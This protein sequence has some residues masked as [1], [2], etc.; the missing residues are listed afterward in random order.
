MI[1]LSGIPS[2][3]PLRLVT[4]QLKE[5]G[6]KFVF[7]NQREFDSCAISLEVEDGVVGGELKL[8]KR[9]YS[10]TDFKGTYSRI[11][12][13]RML[14]EL[15]QESADSDRR[16]HCRNFHDTLTQWME[17]APGCVINRAGPMASN[18]S[19]PYQTQLIRECGFAV[20]E[21]L[22]TNDPEIVREFRSRLGRVVYKSISAVRSIVQELND[23]DDRRLEL[24]RD[25]PIQFQEFVKGTNVRIHT[26]GDIVFATAIETEATDYRYATQQKGKAAELREV[27]LSDD[28]AEKCVKMTK[29]LGLELAGI[30]LKITDEDEVYC[31][32]VNPCPA[33]SYYESHT[34]QK[35]SAAIARRLASV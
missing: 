14:P 16:R 31:F 27:I 9:R 20:P 13:D 4:K 3:T 25:C 8:G 11:M 1:L 23:E 5:L 35:I 34:G 21:T 7:F 29:R 33:F 22:V 32:E 10:L 12:D 17:I 30:D 2:E 15:A 18:S 24:I 26:V 6:S 19:K 28:L